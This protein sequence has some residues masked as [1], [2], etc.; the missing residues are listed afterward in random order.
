MRISFDLD[1]TLFVDPESTPVEPELQFPYNKIYK[2]RLRL[3]AAD[4]LREL[5]NSTVELWLYT[6]SNK[7]ERYIRSYFKHYDVKIDRLI[8]IQN[9][10]DLSP[11][12]TSTDI[13][14]N[15]KMTVYHNDESFVYDINGSEKS[16]T[17]I[18]RTE[19]EHIRVT[20]L[21]E[22]YGQA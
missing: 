22:K 6:A 11:A 17:D 13:H 5:S 4:F 7:S 12:N 9:E 19:L 20:K 14:V 2:D 21:I 8:F 3:G 1:K 15:D 18:I 16:W 10:S